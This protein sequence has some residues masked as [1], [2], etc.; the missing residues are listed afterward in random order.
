M[1]WIKENQLMLKNVLGWLMI[2]F[3]LI[4]VL[5]YQGVF[6]SKT[7]LIKIG[8]DQDGS[9]NYQTADALKKL[10]EK[11]TDYE[12]LLS[13]MANSRAKQTSLLKGD[14]D[15]AFM[16]PAL[17]TQI[18]DIQALALTGFSMPFLLA[19]NDFELNHPSDLIGLTVHMDNKNT[20][21]WIEF[22]DLL[23]H[24]G[25]EESQVVFHAESL[26]DI[27]PRLPEKSLGFVLANPMDP[28]LQEMMESQNLQLIPLT[29]YIR[30]KKVGN[31]LWQL[32]DNPL[33][34]ATAQSF[35]AP[36]ILF[37]HANLDKTVVNDLMQVLMSTEGRRIL[38]GV[39]GPDSQTNAAWL[40]FLPRPTFILNQI[41][42]WQSEPMWM[43][44]LERFGVGI[45]LMGMIVW[46]GLGHAKKFF[47]D[48]KRTKQKAFDQS[49]LELI[50]EL[51]D[52]SE[53]L[54][55]L[56]V[57]AALDDRRFRVDQIKIKALQA[58]RLTQGVDRDLFQVVMSQSVQVQQV[59]LEKMPIN[60]AA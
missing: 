12:F 15:L 17:L 49:M 50:Q 54:H 1:D 20:D 27:F 9:L 21:A 14:I 32:Q 51:L 28:K 11:Q 42:R 30:F 45:V 44:V 58:L 2:A 19:P 46:L 7:Q 25:L 18:N 40:S 59:I 16:N 5:S 55:H 8:T 6:S 29:S 52:L 26:M 34:P 35:S 24:W 33:S 60:Q 56:S 41:T 53:E 48:N 38:A 22:S 57:P 47:Q 36:E 3:L 37:A 13:P 39:S 10:F 43:I 31:P 23:P 4:W